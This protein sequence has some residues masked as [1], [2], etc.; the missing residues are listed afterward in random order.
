[1]KQDS[2]ITESVEVPDFEGMVWSRKG[3]YETQIDF[4][5]EEIKC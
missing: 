2:I 1:M 5:I 3:P 4:L